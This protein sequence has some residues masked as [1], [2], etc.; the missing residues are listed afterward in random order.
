FLIMTA[1]LSP[2]QSPIRLALS[3]HRLN[4][5]SPLAGIKSCNYLE[6]LF[7]LEE[8]RARGF[9][10]AVRLNERGEVASGCMSN[11]F[12]LTEKKLYTPELSTGCLP[13][14]TREFVLENLEC[15]EVSAG[16][17]VLMDAESVFLTSAG[18]GIVKVSE[19]EGKKF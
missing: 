2:P 18:L 12:W 16:I 13:G 4:S 15:K 6:N 17:D 10:E 19:I 9:H 5:T 3:P 7:T 14:T 11:I 1:D 8:A